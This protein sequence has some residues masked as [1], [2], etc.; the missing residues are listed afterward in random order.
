LK[1]YGITP[2]STRTA[3][4][5]KKKEQTAF[6]RAAKDDGSRF[7]CEGKWINDYYPIRSQREIAGLVV[8]LNAD[9]A[10]SMETFPT[11]EPKLHNKRGASFKIDPLWYPTIKEECAEAEDT[12]GFGPEMVRAIAALVVVE[13]MALPVEDAGV[14]MPAKDWAYWF[15]RHELGYVLRRASGTPVSPEAASKQDALHKMTLQRLALRLDAGLKEEFVIGSDEFGLHLFPVSDYVWKKRGTKHVASALKEDKRQYTGDI[16]HNMAGQVVCVEQIWGGKTEAS[17]PSPPKRAQYPHFLFA[18]SVNHW[19][20][21][22]TKLA[23]GKRIWDWVVA[24]HIRDAK[25]ERN[26]D[27]TWEE[28][29]KTAEC[30]WLLDCWPVNLR[31]DFREAVYKMSGGRMEI[32]YVPAGATGRYQVNDTHLHK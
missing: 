32:L 16:A 17:L 8:R 6:D 29:E 21:M 9:R 1:N 26:Q 30:V 11:V 10:K 5:W 20:N 24:E 31:Q 22:D 15:L 7:L 25:E 13:K 18:T 14:W 28:A 23:F 12:P 2:P 4:R 3:Y 19:A 27:L